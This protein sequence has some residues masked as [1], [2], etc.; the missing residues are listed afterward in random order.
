MRRVVWACAWAVALVGCALRPDLSRLPPLRLQAR[1]DLLRQM[2]PGYTLSGSLA[3]ACAPTHGR[4]LVGVVVDNDPRARPQSGLSSACLIYEV[5]TEARIPR[6]L[7]VFSDQEPARVGPVRSVR[8]VFLEIARELDAV[9]AHAGQSLPAFQWIR[10]HRYPVVNE[11]WTPQ[12]FWRS[13]DRRMPHNLYGSVSR[14]REVMRRRGYDRPT[15]PLR[16]AALAYTDPQGSVA[17]HV[18]IGFAAPFRAEFTYHDGRYL[19]TTAGR[20]HLDALTGAPVWARAILVQF[21]TWRGWRSG[22]VEVSEVGVVGRGEALIFAYGRVVEGRWE[23]SSEGAPTVFTDSQGRGLLLPPGP[24]WTILVP[25]GTPVTYVPR[26][27]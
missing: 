6:F 2:K 23:K 14:I 20:P 12:P 21:V 19:R 17:D 24:L 3:T 7:A 1:G 22:R 9:V 5:P 8:P 4:R 25:L 13:R 15:E 10:T 27:P 26:G 16:P 18:R 11:F